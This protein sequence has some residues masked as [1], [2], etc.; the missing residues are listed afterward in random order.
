VRGKGRQKGLE[1]QFRGR[2]YNVDL[3]PKTKIELMVSDKDV[4]K[5]VDLVKTTAYTGNIGDGKIM[6]LPLENIIRI[7]TGESGD[8]AI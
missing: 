4:E 1:L 2:Q 8:K 5:V 7:R 6:I 3:L